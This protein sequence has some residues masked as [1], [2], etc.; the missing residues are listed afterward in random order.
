MIS[1]KLHSLVGLLLLFASTASWAGPTPLPRDV[2]SFAELR[3][4]CDHWRGES[5][6]DE[7]RQKDIDWSICQSCRGTDAELARL[8]RKYR[9][10]ARVM[11]ALAAY[12]P[13]VE[14]EDKA[15]VERFCKM[16][17]KPSWER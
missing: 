5:G 11:D 15:A 10:S 12:D 8:K 16:T 7:E 4:S 14:P 13:H 2:Q 9:H 1:I 3:E 17:R 6:Y